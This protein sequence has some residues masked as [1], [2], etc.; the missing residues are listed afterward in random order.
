MSTIF[1]HKK[2]NCC[3]SP[4]ITAIFKWSWNST[5]YYFFTFFKFIIHEKKRLKIIRWWQ[6][7]SSNWLWNAKTNTLPTGKKDRQYWPAFTS[8][9]KAST[10][11]KAVIAPW[12]LKASMDYLH[13]NS[14]KFLGNRIQHNERKPLL[15]EP[16]A[17]QKSQGEPKISPMT[18]AG[19]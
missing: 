2:N 7:P 18:T 13:E 14:N 19:K 15:Q 10:D 4:F 1:L 8:L 5:P 3:V 12:K 17:W 6:E 16:E 9:K 11:Y